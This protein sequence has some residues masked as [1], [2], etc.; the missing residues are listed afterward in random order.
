LLTVLPDF[1]E[2]GWHSMD[3]CADMLVKHAPVEAELKLSVPR[4]RNLLGFLPSKKAK[5]FDRW[6]NRWRVYPNHV[7]QLA[8]QPGFF[9]IV[10][11]SYAHL[12]HFLP[13]GRVGIYCHD[14]DAFKCVLTPEQETRSIW[15]RKM[16]ARVFEGFKKARVVFCNTKSTQ[17]SIL[18]LGIWKASD[19]I[20]VPLGVAEEFSPRGDREEGVYLLHVGSCIARK[21]IDVLLRALSEVCKGEKYFKL[22]LIQ[23]GGVFSSDQKKQ[24]KELNL[25]DRLEQR[26]NLTREDLARLY[27]GAK[28]LLITSD[29]EGFGLPVIEGLSCGAKVI[30]SDIPA[31]REVG[32]LNIDYFT[33]GDPNACAKSI[34][35]VLDNPVAFRHA[36][37]GKW[38]WVEH[39]KRICGVYE[40][41]GSLI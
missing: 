20:H 33:P 4:Y 11:H 22:K 41:M 34:L 26:H 3:L 14:L 39:A 32:G 25:E 36:S 5:N 10:D 24:I 8:T 6:Y 12:A 9:H 7:K 17:K 30:A 1:R 19:V 2:E 13:E 37:T 38:S 35:K 40:S 27:R 15:F 18:D 23:A 21:R 28:C 31:L 29:A 16:M